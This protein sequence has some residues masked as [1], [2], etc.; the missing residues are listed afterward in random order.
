[1]Q[2]ISILMMLHDLAEFEGAFFACFLTFVEYEIFDL[3][4]GK[5]SE[6]SPS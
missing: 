2:R 3:N 4:Y 5:Y 1:M 6:F